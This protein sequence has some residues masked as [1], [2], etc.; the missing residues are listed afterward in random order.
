MH[1]VASGFPPGPASFLLPSSS[2]LAYLHNGHESRV[3]VPKE[4][5]HGECV[6][7][8]VYVEG[9]VDVCGLGGMG[10]GLGGGGCVLVKASSPMPS[11]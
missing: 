1:S 8:C 4:Y 9:G 11:I 5:E 2:S 7:G 10:V 3:G 6:G